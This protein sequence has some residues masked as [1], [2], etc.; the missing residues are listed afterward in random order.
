MKLIYILALFIVTIISTSIFAQKL[1][2]EISENAGK[3]YG[4]KNYER[5]VELYRSKYKKNMK[6][7]KAKYRFGVC[8]IY[9]Y[10]IADGIKL[11][12]SVTKEA[13][14]PA[15]VWFHLARGYHLSNRYDKATTLYKKYIATSGAKPELIEKS[16]RN[17]EMCVNAKIIIKKPLN[18]SFENLGKRV[19][20]KG[21]D[22]L[23]VIT[24]DEGILLFT[25]RR[26]GTTGRVYD[27]EGYYTADIY[28][29]KYKYGKW[30][31]TRSVGAPNSY[32]NEQTAG[33]SE[34]GNLV[35]Y[36]VNNP[37]SKNNL[38]ISKKSRSSHKRSIEIKSKEINLSGSLQ[39]AATIS[40]DGNYLIFSSDR[41]EG[42]GRKDLY[43]SRKLPNGE[44]GSP[45]N[46][47][48]TINT[49]YDESYPYLSDN[50]YTLHFASTGHNS[51]G[52]YDIFVSHFDLAKKEWSKPVNIGYP[53]NTPYNNT[54]ICF[55]KT[56][57]Y[58]YT[59]THRKDSY[60]GLDI[61]RVDYLDTPPD[62]TTIK[63]FVLDTDSN[64]YNTQ[65]TIEVFDKNTEELYGLY[66]VN[67]EKGSFIM[68][69]P[70]NTYEINIDIP[71]KGYFKQP[72]IVAGRNKY[73]KELNQNITVSFDIPEEPDK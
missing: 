15:E 36:Y 7:I 34:D 6:D 22:F 54:N 73:K 20:S 53:I 25:T 37:N 9:T 66:E 67:S 44:W 31:K 43:I 5:A 42:N 49:T 62:Y 32:G 52:G 65:M 46:M 18:I 51:M 60:G 39:E 40:N 41:P 27:L 23:P 26:E 14:T 10:D 8:L 12:E 58:A 71:G 56:K 35:I 57:K 50:G 61:Y 2:Y 28:L 70:P 1:N 30:S 63:G 38:Q 64:T 47:G 72:L 19:N 59:A 11:L 17:I 21:K 3:M 69:L 68:I 16:N 29:S 4:F 55:N 13:T 24:P 33:I 45:I 48:T